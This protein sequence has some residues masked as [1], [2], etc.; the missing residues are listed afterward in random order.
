VDRAR[1]A[2]PLHAG[3]DGVNIFIG[4]VCLL[5]FLMIFLHIFLDVLRNVAKDAYERG[6][7][8][9]DNWW[10]G[11]ESDADRVRENIRRDADVA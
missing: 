5:L 4:I 3:G 8:D 9:A 1:K 2:L 10:I 11:A 6:R 7:K